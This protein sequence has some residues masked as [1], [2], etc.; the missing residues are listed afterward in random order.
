LGSQWIPDDEFEYRG[1]RYWNRVFRHAQRVEDEITDDVPG[2]RREVLG[3]D[4]GWNRRTINIAGNHDVGYAGDFS[5]NRLERFEKAFGRA[6]WDITFTLP[7]DITSTNRTASTSSPVEEDENIVAAPSIRLL[8]LNNMNLDGPALSSS[9]R[10][11]TYSHINDQFIARAAPVED[12]TVFTILLT[13]I[14]LHKAK[15]VCVDAPFFSYF[16]PPS[17]EVVSS[18]PEET[19]TTTMSVGSSQAEEVDS[20]EVFQADERRAEEKA[21]GEGEDSIVEKEV[22]IG[23]PEEVTDGMTEETS[24]HGVQTSPE[25]AEQPE[26]TDVLVDGRDTGLPSADD[27]EEPVNEIGLP[28][29]EA[30]EQGPTAIETVEAANMAEST[31]ETESGQAASL[32][33]NHQA[34]VTTP[35]LDYREAKFPQQ[36][37]GTTSNTNILS[38]TEDNH[39]TNQPTE[40]ETAN[41]PASSPVSAPQTKNKHTTYHAI[42]PH[43]LREQNHISAGSTR[44]ILQGIFGM[45]AT[46]GRK[47][48][49][50]TGHDHEGCDVVHHLRNPQDAS[51]VTSDNLNTDTVPEEAQDNL[52]TETLSEEP[53]EDIG[54]GE[55]VVWT[56]TRTSDFSPS[57]D[58]STH[59]R[60]ITLRSMMGAYNGNAGLL[61]LWF[62]YNR[63]EWEYRFQT[64][65]LG[66]QHWWWAV[67]VLDLVVVIVA[68]V[69]TIA[70]LVEK[71]GGVVSVSSATVEGRKP[72]RKVEVK[73]G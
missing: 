37:E 36:E 21:E 19:E 59:L 15:G 12:T 50:L 64:C 14:P 56:A 34:S 28:K 11:Q 54:A 1:W 71:D 58:N 17:H 6:N 49:I 61:S 65:A 73:R 48:L 13:H 25:E 46:S 44:N 72:D 24:L 68:I 39:N 27:I 67:H 57:S 52:S 22:E 60:E 43:G 41:I 55:E 32:T 26:Q 7:A 16:P 3:A 8:V 29:L 5:E 31:P 40:T 9:L 47:G 20:I 63:G 66:V 2:G 42:L 35:S 18:R 10:Q 38:E 45:S 23:R 51:T 30:V 33:Q 4:E 69:G 53:V 70:R 62:D